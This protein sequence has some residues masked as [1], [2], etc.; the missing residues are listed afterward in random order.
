M[1]PPQKSRLWE[2]AELTWDSTLWRLYY[3]GEWVCSQLCYCLRWRAKWKDI[4]NTPLPPHGS[5]GGRMGTI[6]LMVLSLLPLGYGGPSSPPHQNGY[7]GGLETF[8]LLILLKA[9]YKQK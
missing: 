2:E 1:M 6:F 9:C 8:E 4:W 3:G 5:Q 7:F